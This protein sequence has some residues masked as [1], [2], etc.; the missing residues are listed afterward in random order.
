MERSRDGDGALGRALALVR[1]LREHCDWDARQTPASLLPY[2]LEEAHETADAVRRDD[3]VELRAELGDLLL[4]IAFQVVLAEERGAFDA[5]DVVRTL[6]AKMVARHPHVYGD[7]TEAPDWET[8]KAAERARATSENGDAPTTPD[9]PDGDR[10]P[11]AGIPGGLEPL[12]RALRVQERAAGIGF[13]WPDVSG[14]MAKLREEIKELESL[15][16]EDSDGRVASPSSA[17]TPPDPAVIEEAGDLLF[18]VVNV[19]RLAGA[20]PLT[21]LDGATSKF[22]RRFRAVIRRARAQ[23]LDPATAG[24]AALDAIWDEVKAEERNAPTT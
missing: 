10:D 9:G 13:D 11:L 20:H 14:A 18:A 4:N 12:S 15:V 7:A 1:H 17:G 19:C 24:L 21:A 6:E 5:A 16:G 3:D 23:G 2:L 8:L 22:S